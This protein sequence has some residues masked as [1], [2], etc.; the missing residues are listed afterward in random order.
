MDDKQ[1]NAAAGGN[2]SKKSILMKG[3][4]VFLRFLP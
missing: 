3:Q 1:D 4:T 2:L